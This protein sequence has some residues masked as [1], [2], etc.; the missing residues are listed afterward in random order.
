MAVVLRQVVSH[1]SGLKTGGLMTVVLRQVVSHGSGLKTGG[2][3]W[4]WS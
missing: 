4:H 1:G 2:L 3:S